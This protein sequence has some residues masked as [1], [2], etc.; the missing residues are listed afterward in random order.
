MKA[1][2]EIL[3]FLSENYPKYSD[4]WRTVIEVKNKGVWEVHQ[5]V[6]EMKVPWK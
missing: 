3:S 6:K 4:V 1:R 5:R 2:A